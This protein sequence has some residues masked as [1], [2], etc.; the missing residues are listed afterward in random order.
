[1][2]DAA[3]AGA[4]A[5]PADMPTRTSLPQLVALC[6]LIFL[7]HAV[8][9]AWFPILPV[10][11]KAL[12]FS[13]GQVTLMFAIITFPGIVSPWIGGYV[14]DRLLSPERT[15]AV[16]QAACALLFWLAADQTAF[17]P[18]GVLLL[19]ATMIHMPTLAITNAIIFHRLAQPE[20]E[21]G[22]VRL[23][24]T[25]SWVV[26]GFVV[27]A[28]LTPGGSGAAS[29]AT[30]TADVLRI[31]AVLSAALTVYCCFLPATPPQRASRRL[32]F[33]APLALLRIRSVAV[34]VGVSF[35]LSL[36]M[37]FVY[38]LASLYLK[39]RG[40]SDSAVAPLLALGQVGEVLAFFGLAMVHRRLGT[41]RT[42]LVGLA[43][44]CVRY[45]IWA[46]GGPWLLVGASLLLH[47]FC[48]AF[49]YGLGQV[50]INR[51]AQGDQRAGAQALYHIVAMGLPVWLGVF[52][53]NWACRTFAVA[54]AQGEPTTDYV[55]VYLLALGIATVCFVSFAA[56]FPAK[57]DPGPPATPSGR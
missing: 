28:W 3:A 54:D 16:A 37:P 19:L 33:F 9:G 36:T 1:M 47:G 20:R 27:G 11:L 26:L 48:Y 39:W 44:W 30:N 5:A 6:V 14:A 24:G 31:A 13:T 46:A 8:L 10:H 40:A 18:I 45:G 17:A 12:G 25:A 41:K 43:A 42:V 15:V 32:D 57:P 4:G 7:D 22:G 29:S 51:N 2:R 53:A 35:V 34:I 38:P 23:W 56:L 55:A 49:V 50:Y 52:L 21:F